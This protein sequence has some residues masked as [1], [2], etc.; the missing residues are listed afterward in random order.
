[1]QIVNRGWKP[2]PYTRSLI[3]RRGLSRLARAG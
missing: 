1:M 3:F 2:V